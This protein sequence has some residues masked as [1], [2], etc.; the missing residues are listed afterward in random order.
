VLGDARV[1]IRFVQRL[2]TKPRFGFGHRT[3]RRFL[4]GRIVK[5]EGQ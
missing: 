5:S 3:A 1:P 4:R 2:G